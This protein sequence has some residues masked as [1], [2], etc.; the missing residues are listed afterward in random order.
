MV[1]RQ[2]SEFKHWEKPILNSFFAWWV[3]QDINKRQMQQ[4]E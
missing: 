2:S 3:E 4:Y 1:F